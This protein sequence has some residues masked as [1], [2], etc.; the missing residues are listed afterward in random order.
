M[1][2]PA[3]AS[4]TVAGELR[5]GTLG[6]IRL[7]GWKVRR[8]ISIVRGHREAALTP[9]AREFRGD[10]ASAM[11]PPVIAATPR[12]SL[13]SRGLASHLNQR[14]M[15]SRNLEF[16]K[17][18]PRPVGAPVRFLLRLSVKDLRPAPPDENR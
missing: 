7:R 2:W 15:K 6:V 8:M 16:C 18:D 3:A 4:F 14:A 10:A 12:A 11:A 13:I 5:V 17:F 9:S 1:A